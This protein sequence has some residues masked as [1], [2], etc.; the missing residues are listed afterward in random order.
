M[1]LEQARI[2]T[3]PEGDE[4]LIGPTVLTQPAPTVITPLSYA[5]VGQQLFNRELAQPE[6]GYLQSLYGQDVDPTEMTALQAALNPNQNIQNLYQSVLGRQADPFGGM[7]WANVFGSEISPEEEAAFRQAAAPEI[8][9]RTQ[10]VAAPSGAP[11][12][13]VDRAPLED[14]TEAVTGVK[15]NVDFRAPTTFAENYLMGADPTFQQKFFKP[16]SSDRYTGTFVNTYRVVNGEMVPIEA[17][18][19][20]IAKGDVIFYVGGAPSADYAGENRVGQAYVI[21]DGQLT[22]I[23]QASEYKSPEKTPFFKEFLLEGVLPM[24]LAAAGPA[25][26]FEGLGGALS[27]GALTGAAASSLGSSAV[28][29]GTQ[30]LAGRDPIDALKSA[31]L[32]YG[33][34]QLANQL[35]AMIPQELGSVGKQAI[36]QL[37]TT[38]K[39]DPLSLATTAG[40]DFAADTLAQETGLSKASASQLVRGGVQLLQGNELAALSS[41][42]SSGTL[43]GLASGQA[44]ATRPQDEAAFLEANASPLGVGALSPIAA[45]DEQI[46]LQQRV[47]NANQAIADYVGPGNDL[48][49]E[50]LVGQLQSLGFT[51]DQAEGY[52]KQADQ[53]INMQRVGSDVMSRYS[54][55]DPEFG[56]PQLD[57]NTAVQ[58]MVAAGFTSDR[59]NEILNGI[60]AQNAIKLENKLSVQSAYNNFLSGKADDDA[61]ISAMI[62]AGYSDSEIADLV[63]RGNAVI[64]GKQLTS[65]EQV[66]EDVAALPDIRA[67]I[68]EKP[69][70]NEAYALAR[71]RLGAGA[72]F[73]WQGKSYSTATAEERPDLS[74]AGLAAKALS[75]DPQFQIALSENAVQ[76]QRNISQVFADYAQ[77]GGDLTREGALSRLE[78]LGVTKDQA[79]FYL[80]QADGKLPLLFDQFKSR[81]P[82]ASE[83]SYR[84]YILAFNEL[85]NK[86]VPTSLIDVSGYAASGAKPNYPTFINAISTGFGMGAEAA[87][88][89]LKAFGTIGESLGLNTAQMSDFGRKLENIAQELYP[90]ALI[91]SE[92]EVKARFANAKTGTDLLNAVKDSFINNPG[93]VAKM[94]GVEGI[95]ELPNIALAL[96]TGGASAALRYGGMLLGMGLDV[97]ESA[98]LQGA[99]KIE[100]GLAKG[101]SRADAVKGA[102]DD[103]KKAGTVTAIMTAAADKVPFGGTIAKTVIKGSASEGA[104]EYALARWTGA[105]HFDALRQAAFGAMIGGPTEA[106]LQGAGNL[107]SVVT[108][109]DKMIGT[110]DNGTKVTISEGAKDLIIDVSKPSTLSADIASTLTANL[111]AGTNLSTAINDVVVGS[112]DLS[113][114]VNGTI[115]GLLTSN[116]DLSAGVTD[117]TLAASNVTGNT[118]AAID[119]VVAGLASNNVNLNANAGSVVVG[120]INSGADVTAAVDATLKAVTAN[121]GSVADSASSIV[122]AVGS[123]GDTTKVAGATAAVVDAAITSGTNVTNT[124]VA[125][126]DSALQVTGGNAATQVVGDISKLGNNDATAAAVVTAVS[127]GADVSGVVDAAITNGADTTVVV[128]NA[129][130]SGIKITEVSR[131]APKDYSA[132]SNLFA[133]AGIGTLG[134][135]L[136]G[137][138]D[139]SRAAT[140]A[141]TRTFNGTVYPT[142]EARNEAMN[143]FYGSTD[144]TTSGAT[145]KAAVDTNNQT[146]NLSDVI[147]LLSKMGITPTNSMVADLT[148]NNAT[149][150]QVIQNL[151]NN[152]EIKAI[153]DA[154]VASQATTAVDN[155]VSAAITSGA[156]VDTTVTA[157]VDGASKANSNVVAAVD[158][159]V[160]SAVTVTAVTGGDVASSVTLAVNGAI[161]STVGSQVTSTTVVSTAID[162]AVGTSISLGS[163]PAVVINA[164]VD[165]A[166]NNN[167]DL[168]TATAAAV[169]SAVVA[170]TGASVASTAVNNTNVITDVTVNNGITTVTSSTNDTSTSIQVG[171]DTKLVTVI[172]NDK[173]VVTETD[174]TNNVTTQTTTTTTGTNTDTFVHVVPPPLG[175]SGTPTG[176]P[177]GTST[178]SVVPTG[179]VIDAPVTSVSAEPPQVTL[180]AEPAKT[181]EKKTTKPSAS[182]AAAASGLITSAAKLPTQTWLDPTI[183]KASG[184]ERQYEDPLAKLRRI[185]E[186][187]EPQTMIN[188]PEPTF[189]EETPYYAYGQEDSIDDILAMLKTPEEEEPTYRQ[190]GMVLPLLQAKGGHIEPTLL[191]SRAV[192]RKYQSPLQ[193]YKG[194]ENF[195]EGKHVA[196]PGD[197]QSDDIPA[198]LADGEF[199]FPADVVSALGNGSTKAGTEKLYQMMHSIRQRA[200]SKG[201][202]DLPPP[203]LKSPLDYLKSRR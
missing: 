28:T 38:G 98:G 187:W 67:Q 188:Q 183:L 15:P 137:K 71:E 3:D 34:G 20:D 108:Q 193:Q 182:S 138:F 45:E 48:S 129:V 66:K 68:A 18:P 31:A 77:K 169:S 73:T 97:V 184:P 84:A 143:A 96:A 181:E 142:V 125:A 136:A 158:T 175:P 78:K 16:G 104:E 179:G 122:T 51:A 94:I 128:S 106:S 154:R 105:S 196:G 170:G 46:A 109:G 58:E 1:A 37:V 5:Q 32:S 155:T 110:Y 21:R 201:P 191:E 22:P 121:G 115:N 7:Y 103:M 126:V 49:R 55:I 198:W 8:A 59:A 166:I 24:V 81:V 10:Q 185:E 163:D 180:A 61:L 147:S 91:R 79:S 139:A 177:A 65:G 161:N 144:Q 40:I 56:T 99:Q 164:A 152:A 86:G 19:A 133:D 123:Q 53:Q 117:L 192:D 140:D 29:L 168:S 23:G 62:S 130:Q 92:D 30:L 171:D 41:L 52:A 50:G 167:V 35:N 153:M 33:A 93:A 118:N 162:A 141:T 145:P 101:L 173:V 85:K 47:N 172:T 2:F 112:T 195:K 100:E 42:V 194:R 116:V 107:T 149:N 90:Q 11:V 190:G 151:Q 189:E 60:D 159:S 124:T 119:Q 14:E 13:G 74:A 134:A 197:G 89:T 17:T 54:K 131:T 36:T 87:G 202:K 9:A 150:A 69:T 25:G 44:G 82:T 156:S 146:A 12:L 102:V 6:I 148:A 88:N 176:T 4:P 27:G 132:Y 26:L 135:S 39:I 63:T 57:R 72:T 174:L 83:D 157:A 43:S 80:D 70:F 95:Q 178:A 165:G 64:A 160:A 120:A 200:R 75:G 111:N 114:A 76:N 186:Q 199:V 127:G 113:A 203:A